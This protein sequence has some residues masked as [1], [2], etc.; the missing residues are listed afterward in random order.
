MGALTTSARD[1][2]SEPMVW[3]EQRELYGNLA[4]HAPF[5]QCF[6]DWLTM[7]WEQGTEEALHT[8][9]NG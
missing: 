5:S 2:K 1:A 8:H 9:T 6:S 4:D 7:I 3:L